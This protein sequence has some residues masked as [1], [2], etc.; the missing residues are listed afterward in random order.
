MLK[1]LIKKIDSLTNLNELGTLSEKT[2][3]NIHIY[4]SKLENVNR[5][6][7]FHND[8]KSIGKI[9]FVFDK[10]IFSVNELV[11]ELGGFK[12]GYSFRDDFTKL[13]F[14]MKTLNIKQIFTK[15]DHKLDFSEEHST[16]NQTTPYGKTTCFTF[17]EKTFDSICFVLDE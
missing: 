14:D 9:N 4:S 12:I 3:K 1:N 7:V 16:V 17:D 8:E 2:S 10:P 6:I 15:L 5:I 13:S 11:S